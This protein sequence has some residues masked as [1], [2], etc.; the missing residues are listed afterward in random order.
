MARRTA[1]SSGKVGRHVGLVVF[2]WHPG[3]DRRA[4]AEGFGRRCAYVEPPRFEQILACLEF[5]DFPSTTPGHLRLLA[6]LGKEFQPPSY[7]MKGPV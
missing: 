3:I 7:G 4:E 2:G 5:F 6:K 1:V